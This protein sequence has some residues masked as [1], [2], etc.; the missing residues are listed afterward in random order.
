V[1]ST[2][3]LLTLRQK[4]QADPANCQGG[5]KALE[6]LTERGKVEKMISF[7]LPSWGKGN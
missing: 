7:D 4:D 6:R 5:S 1:R 3:F 2:F